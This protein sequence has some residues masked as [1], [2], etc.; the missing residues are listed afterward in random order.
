MAGVEGFTGYSADIDLAYDDGV[1]TW[2]AVDVYANFTDDSYAVLN[3]FNSSINTND[4][5]GFHHNDLADA[6]GGS[7]KPS[8]SKSGLS[9][10]TQ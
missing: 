4:G 8:F 3:V 2:Y 10:Y 9:G 5:G 7:W 1:N 6:S